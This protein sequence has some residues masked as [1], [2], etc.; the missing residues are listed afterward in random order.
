MQPIEDSTEYGNR[1]RPLVRPIVVRPPQLEE[2]TLKC[3]HLDVLISLS[4]ALVS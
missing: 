1:R 2:A 3:Y 4:N